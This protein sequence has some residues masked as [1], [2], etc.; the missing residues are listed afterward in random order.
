MMHHLI[1]STKKLDQLECNGITIFKCKISNT[2]DKQFTLEFF[3]ILL[4]KSG[5]LHVN[6]NN[7]NYQLCA[8]NVI[9]VS[10]GVL[11]GVSKPEGNISVQCC[12]FKKSYAATNLFNSSLWQQLQSIAHTSF[13]VLHAK[14]LQYESLHRTCKVLDRKISST[15]RFYIEFIQLSFIQL[16]YEIAAVY[17]ESNEEILSNHDRKEKLVQRFFDI[18]HQHADREHKVKF[19]ADKL[20]VTPGHLN[21]I[22]RQRRKKTVKQ[23]IEEVIISKAKPLL[24]DRALPIK[25]ITEELGFATV[26]SFS[27]FF[28]KN[29]TV[30]PTEYRFGAAQ[31]G[32]GQIRSV[33]PKLVF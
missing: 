14:P 12:I 20:C 5:I 17:F 13:W 21:K 18:L 10:P 26:P 33:S 28:K 27:T 11:C 2:T 29:T 30:S 3:S 7:V 1:N 31:Q 24:E 23:C 19:Y 22:V 4:V 16:I 8:G 6:L 25:E 15:S 9:I 32:T